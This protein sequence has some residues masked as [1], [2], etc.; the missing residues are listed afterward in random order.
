M[1]CIPNVVVVYY[2]LISKII[3]SV[4]CLVKSLFNIS[5]DVQTALVDTV[6]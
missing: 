3:I 1:T 6:K 2:L 4:Y 5:C